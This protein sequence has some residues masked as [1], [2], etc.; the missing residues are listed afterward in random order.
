M[1][2]GQIFSIRFCPQC[3]HRMFVQ[4]IGH[5]RRIDF[6]VCAAPRCDVAFSEFHP[7]AGGPSGDLPS[8]G[9]EGVAGLQ[10]TAPLALSICE[11][12]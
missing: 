12:A 10:T 5:D 3:G 11:V 6:F 9:G 2:P 7:S 4:N 8:G 1:M